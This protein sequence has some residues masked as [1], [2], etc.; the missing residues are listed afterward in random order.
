MYGQTKERSTYFIRKYS[1]A[2]RNSSGASA[3]STSI[4]C[5]CTCVEEREREREREKMS[6][7]IY[8]LSVRHYNALQYTL[9]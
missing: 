6:G 9:L 2:S 8:I 1:I 5:K 3:V 4:F 7:L